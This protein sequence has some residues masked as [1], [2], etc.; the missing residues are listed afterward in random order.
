MWTV[1][2]KMETGAYF[3]TFLNKPMDLISLQTNELPREYTFF[4]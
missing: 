1:F 4:H 3:P 2:E